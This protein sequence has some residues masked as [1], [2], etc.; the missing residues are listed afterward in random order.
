MNLELFV[1]IV[2]WIGTFVI[3][4]FAGGRTYE[5]VRSIDERLRRIEIFIDAQRGT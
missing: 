5:R 3:V 4:V 2:G 1:S